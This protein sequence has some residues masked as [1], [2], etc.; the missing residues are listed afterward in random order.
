MWTTI[1]GQARALLGDPLDDAEE[2]AFID[3]LDDVNRRRLRILVPLMTFVHLVHIALFWSDPAMRFALFAH[4]AMLPVTL[5]LL[6]VLR[7]GGRG[8]ARRA[9]VLVAT[10]YLVH[11]AAAA[12]ADQ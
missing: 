2:R 11:G 3:E 1:R 4:V 8:S 9:G 10:A 6:A 12:G 5:S 7:F